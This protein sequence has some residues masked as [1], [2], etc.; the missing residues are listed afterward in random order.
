MLCLVP[1]SYLVHDG[2][3]PALISVINTEQRAKS[4]EQRAGRGSTQKNCTISSKKDN[5]IDNNFRYIY[6]S[7]RG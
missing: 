7:Y 1:F 2:L 4:R 3:D 5:F 6:R